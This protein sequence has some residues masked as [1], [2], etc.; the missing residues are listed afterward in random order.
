MLFSELYSS[1]YNTVAEILKY[2]VREEL[3]E[4]KLKEIVA[5][6]AF[7]ESSLTIPQ[8]LKSGKWQLITSDYKTPL[9]NEPYMP[10]TTL[11]KRWLKAISLDA[12]VKLFGIDFTGLENIKPLFTPDMLYY[13]DQYA[14]GDD[15]CNEGYIIRFRIILHAIKERQPLK[16]KISDRCGRIIKANVM[17]EYLEYSEKDNKFRLITSGCRYRPIIKLSSIVACNPYFGDE[18]KE[19]VKAKIRKATLTFTLFDGR[20]TL[21]RAMLHFAHFEKTVEK[22]DENHYVVTL[23]YDPNDETELLIR[24]LSFGPFIK[25]T[26]PKFFVNAIKERLKM[27]KRCGI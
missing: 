20:N 15:F 22:A 7:G 25:V 11:Q 17:P 4:Q 2:A 1:Y 6:K 21:E 19:T 26:E 27:Q 18:L 10:L 14:D 8:A 16:L 12:R 9:K 24:I 5:E 3:S 23:T 13:Y